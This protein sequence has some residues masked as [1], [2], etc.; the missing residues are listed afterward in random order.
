MR[1]NQ[2]LIIENIIGHD[3]LV[4]ERYS[5]DQNSYDANDD[6]IQAASVDHNKIVRPKGEKEMAAGRRNSRSD[7]DNYLF[8]SFEL[9]MG[10]SCITNALLWKGGSS[11]YQKTKSEVALSKL[12]IQ[13]KKSSSSTAGCCEYSHRIISGHWRKKH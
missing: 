9:P 12:P 7:T 6:E 3:V 5:Y 8:S 2:N 11:G 4:F 1:I 10:R 13:K